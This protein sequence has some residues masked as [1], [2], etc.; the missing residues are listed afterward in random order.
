M[1]GED[2]FMR[3]LGTVGFLTNPPFQH[4]EIFD[5]YKFSQKCNYDPYAQKKLSA[6]GIVKLLATCLDSG[7]I[8]ISSNSPYLEFE[9]S[10]NPN[11]YQ[12]L[13][14]ISRGV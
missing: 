10:V 8:T 6:V 11:Q 13:A 14:D 12:K 3:F 1:N 5:F 2:G 9:F 7:L 4:G